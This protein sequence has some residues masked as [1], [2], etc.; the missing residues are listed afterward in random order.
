MAKVAIFWHRIAV[1]QGA[2]AA[3]SATLEMFEGLSQ[4]QINDALFRYTSDGS[5]ASA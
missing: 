3:D 2:N 1:E 4:E 5:V